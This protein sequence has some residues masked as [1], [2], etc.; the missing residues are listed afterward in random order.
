ML[1]KFAVQVTAVQS[2]TA[3]S[4]VSTVA[5]ASHVPKATA[6]QHEILHPQPSSI[7]FPL[8]IPAQ[9]F[10]ALP[11]HMP[12]QSFAFVDRLFFFLKEEA[13]G[14]KRTEKIKTKYY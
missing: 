3:P 1:K 7:P 10:C 2:T 11:L 5:Q 13:E 9:S 14:R 12:A 6:G 4:G 8:Q